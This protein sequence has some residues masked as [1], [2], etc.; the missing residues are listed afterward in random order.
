MRNICIILFLI[1]FKNIVPAQSFQPKFHR[2]GTADGLSQGYITCI[3]QDSRGFMWFGTQ[4]GLNR[5]DGYNFRIFKHDPVNPS[6]L[7][8]N[9]IWTIYEDKHGF[10]WIGT[11]QGGACRFDRK[12]ESFTTFRN[13]PENPNSIS[14][15][16]IWS[17][18]ESPDGILWIGANNGLN[19]YDAAKDSFSY[20]KPDGIAPNIFNVL[21]DGEANLIVV[22]QGGLRRFDTA[23]KTFEP[24]ALNKKYRTEFERH[25]PS[26]LIDSAGIFWLGTL[27]EGI[28]RYDPGTEK[29]STFRYEPLNPESSLAG[30]SIRDLHIDKLGQFWA[31]TNK[32]IS[33]LEFSGEE[34][35]RVNNYYY[36]IT[37]QHSLSNNYVNSIYE[38]KGG[39][40]WFGTGIGLNRLELNNQKF[41]HYSYSSNKDNSLSDNGVLAILPSRF[42]SG[43]IWIG[44]RNGL[45]KFDPKTGYFKHIKIGPDKH[46]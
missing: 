3:F 26:L 35:S 9:W 14:D 15:N 23:K 17:F 21:P 39:E 30:N 40:L 22:A 13:D 36:D 4:D 8:E 33:H 34:L 32:G 44:T 46:Q 24:F 11:F 10:L 5:Y 16:T 18:Y 27:N 20:F 43:I 12:T 19:S 45:N 1:L 25:F 6:S 29:I 38:A 2:L 37:D 7:S 31:A 41:L 42:D 28:V